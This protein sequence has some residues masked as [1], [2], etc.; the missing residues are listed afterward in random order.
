MS[1]NK[2][3]TKDILQ[4]VTSQLPFQEVLD[5]M[6]NMLSGYQ[7]KT[8]VE[9]QKLRTLFSNPTKWKRVEK[10]RIQD[11][12]KAEQTKK[13]DGTPNFLPDQ[14]YIGVVDWGEHDETLCNQELQNW[15][16]SGYNKKSLPMLR[17]FIPDY[18]QDN[19]R[20]EVHTTADDT[21]II[22]WTVVVD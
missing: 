7:D 21:R 5:E 9:Y 13:W 2:L 14:F 4:H 15:V 19:F 1:A 16:S 11:F 22:C 17:V 8:S 6:A 20:L 18:D 10:C 12:Q 3:K